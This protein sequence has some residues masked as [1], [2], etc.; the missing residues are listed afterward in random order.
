VRAGVLTAKEAGSF[1]LF[2]EFI[3]HSRGGRRDPTEAMEL[4]LTFTPDSVS[5]KLYVGPVPLGALPVCVWADTAVPDELRA[6]TQIARR[7]THVHFSERQHWEQTIAAAG[8][9]RPED[10]RFARGD[11]A[12]ACDSL[13]SWTVDE[14][15]SGGPGDPG[16]TFSQLAAELGFRALEDSDVSAAKVESIRRLFDLVCR[17]PALGG[18][19]AKRWPGKGWKVIDL[20]RAES[21]L[22]DVWRGLADLRDQSQSVRVDETDLK[23]VCGLKVPAAMERR[24]HGRKVAVRFRGGDELVNEELKV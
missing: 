23:A 22:T 1:A 3:K 20:E 18:Q 10:I 15:F 21:E 7:L 24:T 11:Y 6:H 5:H 17:A 12:A 2:D 19:D 8:V 16:P 4:L 9:G 14:L 13:L